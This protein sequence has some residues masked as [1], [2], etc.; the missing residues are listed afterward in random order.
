MSATTFLLRFAL[1]FSTLTYNLFYDPEKAN[2]EEDGRLSSQM[3]FTNKNKYE[4]TIKVN[5]NE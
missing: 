2:L 4:A 5:N 3:K 1:K